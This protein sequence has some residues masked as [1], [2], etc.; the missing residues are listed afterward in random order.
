MGIWFHRYTLTPRRR[1]S[2]VARPGPREGALLRFDDGFADL[3]PW[4]ELGDPGL[5]DQLAALQRG[6][7][8]P[9]VC[10]SRRLAEA[11]GLA[12]RRGRS[13][14]EGLTIP[15]SYWSGP[16]PAEGFDTAKVKGT[17]DLPDGVRL[18]IDFNATLAADEFLAAAGELPRERLDY[19]E[20]PMRFDAAVWRDV[21]KATGIRLALDLAAPHGRLSE[22]D[23]VDVI[24]H[25][26]AVQ[27][28]F[29]DFAGEIVVTTYMDHPVGQY[30]AAWVA[31]TNRVSRRCGLFTHV[32]FEPDPFVER[33]RAE[34]ARLLPPAG[35][36]I[37]FDDLL[38]ALPWKTLR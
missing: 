19:V 8:S 35:T 23:G 21:R 16:D 34:G 4:P 15:E 27:E 7:P 32:L 6:E 25:K 13:L 12:R 17:H 38:E 1:L 20:D 33:V 37:G 26:P 24:V 14:F 29:P 22:A 11:D 9:Q 31:A 3:H 2:G 30:G 10:A 36:G 18:R 28:R 5:D